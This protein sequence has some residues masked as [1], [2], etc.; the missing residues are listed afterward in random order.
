MLQ[1]LNPFGR[2]DEPLG[3]DALLGSPADD[4]ASP[5]TT[6]STALT[7][8][9]ALCAGV[10]LA[11]STSA[12]APGVF[13]ALGLDALGATLSG[14][15]A[16]AASVGLGGGILVFGGI[17]LYG[18]GRVLAAV[19]RAHL[20]AEEGRRRIPDPLPS[21]E[22][23]AAQQR[24]LQSAMASVQQRAQSAQRELSR[25]LQVLISGGLERV[26]LAG[27]T[28]VALLEESLMAQVEQLSRAMP[29]EALD[30]LR[31]EVADLA[32]EIDERLERGLE[33]ALA[34]LD[35]HTH[36]G[37][38]ER[39]LD[40]GGG[41]TRDEPLPEG[42]NLIHVGSGAESPEP[43]SAP[44]PRRAMRPAPPAAPVAAPIAE[45][46]RPAEP[47]ALPSR[48]QA[49]RHFEPAAP[50]VPE[51]AAAPSKTPHPPEAD[52]EG[53]QEFDL[54]ALEALAPAPDPFDL[55][56]RGPQ[57]GDDEHPLAFEL[58]P[59]QVEEDLSASLEFLGGEPEPPSALPQRS[60]RRASQHTAGQPPAVQP[61][62]G[63]YDRRA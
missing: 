37:G 50:Q 29:S 34:R 26:E 44:A 62:A 19:E 58:D 52:D 53:P 36:T 49:L 42:S 61:P 60:Q 45:T 30:R 15:A 14:I 46:A 33:R 51:R 40:P 21:M 35:A 27:E 9:G 13:G 2:R 41:A 43:E 6:G 12:A 38:G 63:D 16:S 3:L 7:L 32:E 11:L 24:Q 1:R 10:G 57:P 5:L 48:A 18:L 28:R 4:S 25:S 59:Q 23:L 39:L 20:A 56:G 17:A 54:D 47:E 55:Y 31:R 8:G 22:V